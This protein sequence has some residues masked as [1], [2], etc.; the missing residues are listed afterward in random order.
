MSPPG[1]KAKPGDR[2]FVHRVLDY[3]DLKSEIC[4]CDLDPFGVVIE[5]VPRQSGCLIEHDKAPFDDRGPFGWGYTE[6]NWVPRAG[7]H[8]ERQEPRLPAGYDDVFDF[9]L[10]DKPAPPTEYDRF[11][12]VILEVSFDE[13][14]VVFAEN[15]VTN[16]ME[17]GVFLKCSR[18]L[19][20]VPKPSRYEILVQ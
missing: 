1:C 14:K 12:A 11:E 17:L 8:W 7:E 4:P 10:D 16:C 5:D 20:A 9:L 2:V 18:R 6:F 3:R 19:R 13:Q 15:G